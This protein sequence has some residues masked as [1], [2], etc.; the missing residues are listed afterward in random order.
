MILSYNGER[1]GF[2]Y[3]SVVHVSGNAI[4]HIRASGDGKPGVDS[5]SRSVYLLYD[6]LGRGRGLKSAKIVGEGGGGFI[7]EDWEW[8]YW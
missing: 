8:R 1:N 6:F 2:D 4:L 3:L 7:N 5:S